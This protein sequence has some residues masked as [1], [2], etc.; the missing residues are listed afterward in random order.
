[1]KKILIVLAVFSM[2]TLFVT[3]P[4]YLRD[5]QMARQRIGSLE[6][7]VI[8]TPVAP[9][10]FYRSGKGAPILISHGITGG[11]DQGLGLARFYIAGEYDL[12]A[13]S[14]F[15]YLGSSLPENPSPDAQAEAYKHLL[16]RL[17]IDKTF[18]FGNS[19]GGTSAIRFALNY[20]E[21]CSGLILV[22]SNVPSKVAMPPK[23]VM[24]TVF[25]S[26]YIY[27]FTANVLGEN[28]LPSAG[29]TTDLLKEMTNEEKMNLFN[30]VIMS[31]F[32]IQNRSA[33]V[34]NDMFVSNPDINQDYPFEQI[35]VPVLMI[36]AKDDP[37]CSFQG[38]LSMQQKIPNIE[39]ENFERGGHIL[40]GH[41]A[42]IQNK[43]AIFIESNSTSEGGR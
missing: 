18:V 28:M 37:L 24:K 7:M 6:S 36:H 34:I 22:S 41:E 38:A 39:I 15:G 2:I 9:I 21:R 14:R 12:I 19:A 20:P 3:I 16:D 11:F 25:G 33:G 40:L 27:W 30:D 13:V 1:M 8:H 10:E 42:E 29:V 31:G 17:G 32:P 23:L 43:I 5:L 4:K 26:N 35:S